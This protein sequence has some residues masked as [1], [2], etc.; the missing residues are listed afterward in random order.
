MDGCL[1]A[2]LS[3]KLWM[4][5]LV[6]LVTYSDPSPCIVPPFATML[7]RGTAPRRTKIFLITD[8]GDRPGFD[9]VTMKAYGKLA[10]G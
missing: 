7:T 8:D 5:N 3:E 9:T 1:Q 6:L 4:N 10:G 2:S